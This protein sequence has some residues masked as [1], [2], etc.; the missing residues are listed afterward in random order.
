MAFIHLRTHSEYSVVDG[1]LRVDD[2]ARAAKADQQPALALTDL[3]NLFGA[4]KFYKA[5]RGQGVKPL[6]GVDIFLEPDGTTG[7]KQPSRLLLLVHSRQGYLNLCELLARGW[8]LN[9]QRAQAW[10][11]WDW[12][13]ELGGGLI[14]LSGADAGAV[15]QALLAGDGER[16][17]AVAQRLADLFPNR[18]YIELQRAGLSTHQAHVRAAVPLA[19]ALG[20]PVVATHPVQFLTTDDYDAHEARVCVAEGETLDNAK[21]VRR[22]SREQYFKSQA[23]MQTLFAD[24]PSAIANTE[25]IAQRC[26]LSLEMGKNYLPDFPTP[27][28]VDGLALPIDA[29]F[30][31]ASHAGLEHRLATLFP[32]P[33]QRETRRAEY[34]QRLEFEIDTILKMGFSGYFLIVA[35]FIAWAR[36]NGCP[37]GP[38]RG[39][40]AGSLVAYSL[41]ITDLD[42]LHYQLLFERFLNPERVSMPDFDIDFCQANRDRVI[43]Y[44]KAKYGRDAVSQIAT[45][46]TMAAK[47]ALRDIGRV[48]GMGYGHVD[49][50]AKLIPAPPGKTVTL[51]PVPDQ[52]EEGIVY[53]RKEAPELGQREAADEAVAEL[54]ALATRV[55]GIVRNIGTHAGGVLIAPGKIT[56]FCPLY[57]QPGSDSAVSQYDKDDVEAI[58]LV[59]FDFLGLATLTILEL[60]KDMIVARHADRRDFHFETVPLDDPRVYRLFAD[61]LT[62]SVFQ[63]ESRGMQ[64]ML[65][66]ARPT[67]LEDLIALNAMFRPGPMENI[68][69]FCARKNGKEPVAYPHPLLAPVLGET[70]GIMVYQEQVMQAAQVLGGYSLGGADLLR[71]AMGK[72]KAEEMAQHR[73]IFREGAAKQNIGQ[74]KADEVFD[75]M[76]KFAGYGFNKSHAA[77]YSL[78]AYH[79]GW[80]KVHYTAEFYAA[81]MTVEM[82]DTDKLKVL[83]N[84]AKLFG[85]SFE[86]PDINRG[87]YRFEPL[88]AKLVRYGLGAIKGTGQGAIEAIVEARDG[89]A[90]EGG[91]P[92]HSFFDFC[93]RVDRKR[94]NKRAVEALIKAGAFDNLHPDRASLL[95]SVGLGFDWADT[96]I[97]NASQGGLFDDFGGDAHGSSTQEPPLAAAE[98]WD[99]RERLTQ[100]KTAIGFFLSGHL[101]EQAQAEVGRF[102]KRRIADLVDSREPQLLA[103]IVGDVRIVSGQRGRVAIFALDDGSEAIESVANEELIDANR[104][105]LREDE[106]VIVQGKVQNDRFSGGLRLNITQ[107]WDLTAARARFGRYLQL[108]MAP[109]AGGQAK[110]LAEL[111]RTWPPRLLQTEQGELTQGLPLRLLI[112]SLAR[113]SAT[114]ELDLGDAGRFW[115]TDAALARLKS[116]A[117]AGQAAIVYE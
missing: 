53:A 106:L 58:G 26:N 63:F 32:D 99:V 94:V 61:G 116:I 9:A 7:E 107:V 111:V 109:M 105:L 78:L 87:G 17:K 5:C 89:M 31:Q 42:P 45:F 60:A 74:T 85:V 67:R 82:G 38:G 117:A 8:V 37:V 6:I 100:E 103:G 57:Q 3:S 20:L 80:L 112:A 48:L 27:L 65:R 12:L 29:Y 73:Q 70:Y 54:L 102:C 96:Q 62:E 71:R 10:V 18:F 68:P 66:E 19:A 4:V 59:K 98:P 84:D 14:A 64:G 77:A 23:Q 56:D 83:R 22:F 36:A 95:G 91:G 13:A 79:T 55:E 30:R 97:V 34:T 16:A 33:A 76:E 43:D 51:A 75:L 44:V 1:T 28:G 104:E 81:N 47:A 108:A 40:G 11:K 24:L 90:G 86:P 2:A 52:P 39:S 93:G 92:F 41:K 21:R 49:S 46:G 114:A 72:K 35:D 101:F 113:P 115:P 50:I 69:S 25:A 110:T 15:G 88:N